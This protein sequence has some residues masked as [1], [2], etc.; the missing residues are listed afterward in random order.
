MLQQIKKLINPATIGHSLNSLSESSEELM[1]PA[2]FKLK[3]KQLSLDKCTP[4][5]GMAIPSSPTTVGTPCTPCS[6]PNSPLNSCGQHHHSSSL[7][8][9]ISTNMHHHHSGVAVEKQKTPR[10]KMQSI[11][12]PNVV[13]VSDAAAEEKSSSLAPLNSIEAILEHFKR[14]AS[15]IK[16]NM[17]SDHTT[18]T[19][20]LTKTEHE[21]LDYIE[22][23]HKIYNDYGLLR[24]VRQRDDLHIALALPSNLNRKRMN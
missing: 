1:S 21:A 8:S 4:Q 9:A 2:A 24:P 15:S 19:T 12:Q 23:E 13:V 18:S 17:V 3:K 6:L 22:E 14:S 5:H 10:M 16:E 7:P 11:G 20:P